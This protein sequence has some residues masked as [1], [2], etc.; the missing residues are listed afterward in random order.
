MIEQTVALLANRG[1]LV[2]KADADKPAVAVSCDFGVDGIVDEAV[3]GSAE[4][5]AARR[6]IFFTMRIL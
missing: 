3:A 5:A 1:G 2:V 4:T 6:K